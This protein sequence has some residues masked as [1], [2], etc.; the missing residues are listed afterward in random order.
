M[1][2]NDV[3]ELRG[4][5]FDTLRGLKNKEEALDIERVRLVVDT[6]QAITATAKV[7]ADFARAVGGQVVSK[8]IPVATVPALPPGQERTA[9]G[10]KTVSGHITTHRMAE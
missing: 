2:K 4:I 5:L 3:S 10:I 8:F 6:A 7:E 9:H 1:M